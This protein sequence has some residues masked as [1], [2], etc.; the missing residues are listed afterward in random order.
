MLAPEIAN[1]V[2]FFYPIGNTPA[3]SL[4]Q[5]LPSK[6]KADL[7]LLGCGD[8]R[9]ILFTVHTEQQCR[10][11][12]PLDVTCCDV[13][14]A[15]IARNIVL[16]SLVLDDVDGANDQLIWN[17][18][19]H[20]RIDEGSLGL[21]Q[22]QTTK[23][24]SLSTSLH[25]WQQSEYGRVIRMCDSIS[26]ERVR[27]L[28]RFYGEKREGDVLRH[29]KK[30]LDDG[31]RVSQEFQKSVIGD[32][33][34]VIT[35]IRAAAPACLQA[36]RALGDL[37]KIY[38]AFGT[39]ETDKTARS[40]AVNFNPMFAPKDGN[41]FLHYGTDPV[42]GFHIGSSYVPIKPTSPHSG[43]S[44][45]NPELHEI[46]K[47]AKTEFGTWTKSF[48]AHFRADL[49]T[50]RF[51]VGDAVAFAYT[52]QQIRTTGPSKSSHWYRDRYHFEPLVLDDES[53]SKTSAPLV[54]DVIDTSNL[55][56]HL[57]ALNLLTATS[58]LLRN[59]LSATLYSEKL[60]RTQE[61]QISLLETLLCGDMP[62]V[63]S[64]L[65]LV[66]V[67]VATSTAFSS[68]GDEALCQDTSGPSSKAGQ[69]FSRI[70]WKRPL[71][72]GDV[73]INTLGLI[74]FDS[75]GLAQV[76]YR[77]LL[78]MFADA[79]VSKLLARMQSPQ[80]QSLPTYNRAS[81]VAFLCLVKT[82]TSA[83]W[84]KAM[85]D[86]LDLM[87]QDTS[88]AFANTYMQELCLWM[89]LKGLHSVDILKRSPHSL[90]G[91]SQTGTLQG[92]QNM[93]P[94]VSVTLRVPRSKLDPFIAETIKVG[95]TP[96][97]HAILQSSPRAA[98]QWQNMFAETQIGFGTLNAK[99]SRHS[100]SFEVEIEEDQ[101]GWKGKSPMF[102]S[103]YVPSWILLQEPC[104]AT[105]SL[106]IP[107]SPTTT[108]IFASSLGRNL[109]IFTAKQEEV[110][111][112]YITKNQPHQSDVMSIHGFY[113]ED[114]K[115]EVGP[116]GNSETT[117]T[118]TVNEKTGQISSFTTRVQILSEQSKALLKDGSRITQSLRSPFNYALSL[119][120]G[121]SFNANFPA[122][123]L[124][125]TV[126]VRIARKSSYL[127]LVA[128]VAKSKDW[129]A[130]RSFMYPVF[131]DSG[132]PALWNMP[133]V[134]LS[135]LP[136]IDLNNPSSE[137][138]QWLRTHLPTMWSAPE[139]AVKFNP[140]LPAPPNTRARVDFKDGLFHIFL[141]FSG[142]AGPQ[143]SVYGIDCPEEK[144][145][146]MLV[147]VSKMLLDISNRTTVLDAAVLP[148]YTDLMP[149]IMPAL[150]AMA[151]STHSPKS[152]RTSRDELHLWKEA[153]PAW[154]ERCRSWSHK[155]SCEYVAT[156]KIPLS[157][158]FGERVLCSC[159][160]GTVPTDF[161]PEFGGWKALA[162]HCV[163]M[164]ISPAFASA[165]VDKPI[166]LSALSSASDAIGQ[167]LNGC[168]VCGKDEDANGSALMNCSRC[169]KAKYCS[170]DCQKVDWKKHK[171]VCKAD[172]N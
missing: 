119:K 97:L 125:S 127:E 151:S 55:I 35:G 103:F 6:K 133:H 112:V 141:G 169:H 135:S 5:D 45:A 86:L 71:N 38:W 79:D 63:T 111:H 57:G 159:G 1:L 77:V 93:P 83:D 46:V 51:F 137:R 124:D 126:R 113:S 143:A 172:G 106:A 58:P 64:L 146:Q 129:S 120:N 132:S 156:G 25:T 168:Q 99:G 116:D 26:L 149:Q 2:Q 12:R 9:H 95:V 96:P 144:G 66:P 73:A 161:M 49:V 153:L 67:E 128:D 131:L 52:L 30:K 108:R 171:K 100:D 8:V 91:H 33:M 147:F 27:D 75:A 166:D 92:W 32:N 88:P 101:L 11:P 47:T 87:N 72:S 16:L 24:L 42:L 14:T 98:S 152:I 162:K 109:S 165:L 163:R 39:T 130:L 18:F 62:T 110:A 167:D 89:H 138:L 121:P 56:D 68:A 136:T 160:K 28:W 17:L 48:R 4:T 140:S 7:L 41:M 145:V 60:V 142:T 29:F 158:K 117:I 53:Y 154:T 82:R 54:F 15:V 22:T 40:R 59:S 65:A 104:T 61:T 139:T 102:I 23:L 3:V 76:L 50:L 13:D 69:V 164:A 19:Y 20:F 155:P 115:N 134:N 80:T 107:H 90:T 10:D 81:F 170:R 123:V 34:S 78:T 114:V 44:A 122:P 85:E 105:V 37:Y 94:M 84:D 70:A 31:M 74:H 21:L 43:S 118:A 148:L 150:Q 36:T 157:I